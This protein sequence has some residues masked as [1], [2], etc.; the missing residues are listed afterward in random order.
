[1]VSQDAWIK[2]SSRLNEWF[3]TLFIY[4]LPFNSIVMEKLPVLDRNELKSKSECN[5]T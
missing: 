5:K 1:M 3:S 4:L 2:I